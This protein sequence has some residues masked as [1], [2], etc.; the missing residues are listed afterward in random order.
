MNASHFAGL[1]R[2]SEVHLVL[3]LV[4]AASSG[5]N[6][7]LFPR[8][9]IRHFLAQN[10]S[11]YSTHRRTRRRSRVEPAPDRMHVRIVETRDDGSSAP[12]IKSDR[13]SCCDRYDLVTRLA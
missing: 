6:V 1:S 10:I 7:A 3:P 13:R 12:V 11:A 9:S 4:F 5:R 8:C 2:K